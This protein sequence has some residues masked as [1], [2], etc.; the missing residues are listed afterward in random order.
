V[1]PFHNIE[2]AVMRLFLVALLFVM[3][4]S[5][6]AQVPQ[7]PEACALLR[8]DLDGAYNRFITAGQSPDVAMALTERMLEMRRK[9][10]DPCYWPP[11]RPALPPAGRSL[12]ARP[13][14][15]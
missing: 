1:F 15:D 6:V 9:T 5:A 14:N 8:A 3:L 10:G 4:G 2:E 12:G 11:P 7:N 13:F